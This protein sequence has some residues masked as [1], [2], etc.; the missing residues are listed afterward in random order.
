MLDTKQLLHLFSNSIELEGAYIRPDDLVVLLSNW[1]P[2][3]ELKTD[4][5]L[6]SL[7][8]LDSYIWEF[9]HVQRAVL[10]NNE[11]TRENIRK[12]VEG[13]CKSIS[14][15]T[16]YS[17]KE[18]HYNM[19]LIIYQLQ[20]ISL[21][22]KMYMYSSGLIDTMLEWMGNSSV[23]ILCNKLLSLMLL[24]LAEIGFSPTQ[25]QKYH[26]YI[27]DDHNTLPLFYS[28]FTNKNILHNSLVF[29][30]LNQVMKFKDINLKNSKTY[31]IISAWLKISKKI[32]YMNLNRKISSFKFIELLHTNGAV[33]VQYYVDNRKLQ[34][35]TPTEEHC[36]GCFIFEP[37]QAYNISLCHISQG[38]QMT[39]IDLYVNG[40]LIESKVTSAVFNRSSQSRLLFSKTIAHSNVFDLSVSGPTEC[41]DII[42]ETTN[43]FII[44]T[45]KFEEWISYI[46]H[47]GPNFSGTFTGDDIFSP[48]TST[49]E[50]D[51]YM[52][53]K[54]N[55]MNSDKLTFFPLDHT[56]L[57]FLWNSFISILKNNEVRYLKRKNNSFISE[58]IKGEH[59]LRKQST[60]LLNS[61]EN[62]GGWIYCLKLIERSESSDTLLLNVK[63]LLKILKYHKPSETALV[64]NN[65][66]EILA[67]LLKSKKHLLTM[68]ILDRI[69]KFVGYNVLQPEESIIKSRIAYKL[70]ILDFD[71]W[72][73]SSNIQN[74]IVTNFLLFQFTVFV[75]NSKY[76][77]FNIKQLDG[78]NIVKKFLLTLKREN[79]SEEVLP[80]IQNVLKIIL[81]YDHSLAML[82]L[83]QLHVLYT[84]NLCGKERESIRTEKLGGSIILDLID[85]LTEKQPKLLKA[86]TIKFLLSLFKGNLSIRRIG[87]RLLIKTVSLS[88]KYYNSFLLFGGF[89]ILTNYLKSDWKDDEILIRLFQAVFPMEYK[90][91]LTFDKLADFIKETEISATNTPHYFGIINNLMKFAVLDKS[92][93]SDN[94]L[95][96]YGKV[97]KELSYKAE[98]QKAFLANEEWLGN[99]IFLSLA[100]K[101]RKSFSLYQRYL[102]LLKDIMIDQIYSHA[103]TESIFNV[104]K[105]WNEYPIELN[106]IVTPII[107]DKLKSFQSLLKL[108]LSNTNRAVTICRIMTFYFQF[109]M[110]SGLKSD[111]TVYLQ[112]FD[113][114]AVVINTLSLQKN[115]RL[116]T[117]L[118]QLVYNYSL[119]FISIFIYYVHNCE[120]LTP[121]EQLEKLKYCCKIFMSNSGILI[122]SLDNT[123][124]LLIFTIFYKLL[125]IE[126]SLESL[127]SN[128][129]R[130]LIMEKSD[131][132]DYVETILPD[133]RTRTSLSKILNSI[134]QVNDDQVL[135][136]F[137]LDSELRN[138]LNTFYDESYSHF[139]KL[140]LFLSEKKDIDDYIDYKFQ[141]S[142]S[143]KLIH[144]EL[145]PFNKLIFNEE[146]RVLNA[147][148]Q[149]EVDDY[150]YYTNI[151]ESL[152]A[153]CPYTDV[154]CD[155]VLYS[156]EGKS[157]R[158][159]KLVKILI[160]KHYDI[161]DGN[162]FGGSSS[163]VKYLLNQY[164][165]ENTT[166]QADCDLENFSIVSKLESLEEGVDEDRNRRILRN[167]YVHDQIDE[168]CNV[169]LIVG[170]DA[171]ESVLVLGMTHI[172]LVEGYFFNNNGTLCNSFEAPEEQRDKLV[173]LLNELS[174]SKNDNNNMTKCPSTEESDTVSNDK[175]MLRAHKSRSWTMNN[176]I[177][178]SKRNFL[179][180]DVGFELF[181]KNGASLLLTFNDSAKRNKIFNKLNSSI[182]QKVEDKNFEDALQLSS[183][184]TVRKNT[185]FPVDS[186]GAESTPF[187]IV[188]SF[189]SQTSDVS[190]SQITSKWCNGDISN[191]QYLMYLNTIAGRTFND[192][193]QYPIFPFV[194]SDYTSDSIDLSDPKV[195]R[196]LTKPMG[197]QSSTR[198][199]QFQ[200]RYEATKD[201]SADTLPFHYGTHYSSAM[202]VTSFL[203]RL[204]PFTESYL[205]LQGGKFDH[206]DRLF[207]S[208]PKLWNSASRE[209]TT[210]VRELIPEFYYLPEFLVNSNNLKLGQLQNGVEVNDV[211]LPKWADKDPVKFVRVMRDAL[212]SDY[213]NEYL[214]QWIDLIFGYKQQGLEAIN[215]TNVFHY[216]SYPGSIDLDQ[217]KDEHERAVI[218]SIIHNFGQ[219]PLQI[220]RK[221]HPMKNTKAIKI[222]NMSLK[223]IFYKTFKNK[224][225]SSS[226][227]KYREK[228]NK[229]NNSK[230]YDVIYNEKSDKWIGL[231][232]DEY[233]YP[234]TDNYLLK[235]KKAETSG[236]I[237]N[238]KYKFE[239]LITSG[240]ITIVKILGED[241]FIVGFSNGLMKIY[242][243]SNDKFRYVLNSERSIIKLESSVINVHKKNKFFSSFKTDG[244]NDYDIGYIDRNDSENKKFMLLEVGVLFGNH[245]TD[246]LKIAYFKTERI[247]VS[248][249]KS[250]KVLNIW[251]EADKMNMKL[252]EILKMREIEVGGVKIIDFD[253]NEDESLIYC[254]A[255][256]DRLH[257]WRVNGGLVFSGEIKGLR[258]IESIKCVNN[259]T[260]NDYL[261]GILFVLGFTDDEGEYKF[262][263][264]YLSRKFEVVEKLGVLNL[265]GVEQENR[266]SL[267]ICVCPGKVIKVV[268]GVDDKILLVE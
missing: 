138:F 245:E 114:S 237:I 198:E 53:C 95:I 219:T 110:N 54:S 216:L 217:I 183:K 60:T 147:N 128:C 248:L 34:M 230:I 214:P 27:S 222:G 91:N 113:I 199:R 96:T 104:E 263:V 90:E 63:F 188:D 190:T 251:H 210:D 122:S 62:L 257:I 173:K 76:Y 11:D 244:I 123:T 208:I 26:R 223:D 232:R 242:E 145:D 135:E 181:F 182:T 14:K 178:V 233:I 149:D 84:I 180:R 24:E 72:E 158:R 52:S 227:E 43:L 241:K 246:I 17:D 159:N 64:K 134:L 203:I 163:S 200:D 29:N 177:S 148:N 78:M 258:N 184:Q 9:A 174:I 209:N 175:K 58:V 137:A 132:Y 36:F 21:L 161:I 48:V 67:I 94:M 109:S 126:K 65:G 226:G 33:L 59:L 143:T 192:L 121:A 31:V 18:M 239:P 47:V 75:Q 98:F 117:S 101:Q 195:Y 3:S 89:S 193:T 46:Y 23:D 28:M 39:R 146:M 218:V 116:A 82:K 197:A 194:L 38:K 119:S 252:G 140:P 238:D 154:A 44:E 8:S 93:E 151:F 87:L 253:I 111:N 243:F 266:N 261:N 142:R 57:T 205:K 77:S 12:I 19:L 102:N 202:I 1:H 224:L 162:K 186:T 171:K 256:D 100:V 92:D 88:R 229:G 86:L 267:Q 74:K 259:Y 49:R 124:L 55:M 247:I 15:E 118:K 207:H 141:L 133:K 131:F 106:T 165:D 155:E 13:I 108:T 35:V 166:S 5:D 240:C 115:V 265:T 69:L 185:R 235:I 32:N 127:G 103:I 2:I 153:N 172:Y 164:A 16:D 176:L 179:L 260:E 221:K 150:Y 66:Y 73:C 80:I 160:E 4:V 112:A 136:L 250:K 254:I 167:L 204:F 25:L 51:I 30:E 206:A 40:V 20:K 56:D 211:E 125:Y 6:E 169:T 189:L 220:V 45:E 139:S 105:L 61:F 157:R 268:V 264:N 215:A 213:V 70:L 156:S 37:N 130:V 7:M 97:L 262:C 83:L 228:W 212:E 170:L 234:G 191:F 50:I 85:R 201:M 42:L 236:L 255:E 187:S 10:K 249:D 152:K 71:I 107:Y 225:V 144:T 231:E 79:F 22:N 196:D 168:I 68:D 99:L 120:T 41:D 129:I 81:D